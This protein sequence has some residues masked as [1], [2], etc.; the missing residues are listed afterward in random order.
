MCLIG[1]LA[2]CGMMKSTKVGKSGVSSTV[3]AHV[4]FEC[5]RSCHPLPDKKMKN[6]SRDWGICFVGNLGFKGS[7]KIRLGI[8]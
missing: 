2:R 7:R 3:E 5:L 8:S 1:V 4:N 6:A